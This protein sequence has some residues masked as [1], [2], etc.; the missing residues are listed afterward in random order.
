MLS[1][2]ANEHQNHIELFI[3]SLVPT[4]PQK[5]YPQDRYSRGGCGTE[6]S[7]IHLA[8]AGV[9]QGYIPGLLLPS[10]HNVDIPQHPNTILSTFTNDTTILSLHLPLQVILKCT[11]IAQPKLTQQIKIYSIYTIIKQT[12]QMLVKI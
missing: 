8:K 7:S 5:L 6:V 1:S 2:T 3:L 9:C 11:S 12:N 4:L 10:L